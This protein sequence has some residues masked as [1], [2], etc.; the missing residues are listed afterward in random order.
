[1]KVYVYSKHPA[2]RL[3]HVQVCQRL[4][5]TVARSMDNKSTALTE[6]GVTGFEDQAL[7][8]VQ[9]ELQLQ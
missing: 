1:M 2:S 7:C 8:V 3:C 4:I 6:D 5:N 9:E